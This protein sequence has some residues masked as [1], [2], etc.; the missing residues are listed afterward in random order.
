L[1]DKAQG[2][3]TGPGS[4]RFLLRAFKRILGCNTRVL[5]RMAQMDRALS[6]EYVFDKTF[7]E[8]GVR[9]VCALTHR[10]V[11]H[12][13]GM[14]GEG[15]VALYDAFLAVKDVLEDILAGGMGHLAGRRVLAFAE[16]SLEMEPLAGLASVGLAELGRRMGLAEPE[17]F[18]VTATGMRALAGPDR[19]DVLAEIR[20]AAAGLTAGPRGL[21][22]TLA[23][24]GPEAAGR[25]LAEREVADIE[26]AL[27]AIAAFASA[28]AGAR[29]NAAGALAVCI[30]PA[31]EARLEGW[32]E[33]RA[34]DPG[35]PPSMLVTFRPGGST[36]PPGRAWLGRGVPHSVCRGEFPLP[37]KAADLA[38]LGL[39]A[40][41]LLGGA[42]RLGW[43]LTPAGALRI[44]GVEPAASPGGSGLAA[45]G[46]TAAPGNADGGFAADAD[47]NP[48]DLLALA[49]QIAC[50]GVAAGPLVLL[51]EETAPESVP[52]GAVGFAH[53]ATP[54][55]SRLVPRLGA[56]LA[57]V[58]TAASHL[59][60][61]ARENRVPALF[62]VKGLVDVVPGTM[63]TVDADGG[64]VYRGVAEGLLRQ[65]ASE[66]TRAGFEP[67]YV[68]LRRLLRHIRPLSLVDPR[69]V[70][71]TPAHCRTCHDII[72]FVH[73][74]AVERLLSI[75][76]ADTSGLRA[77]RRFKGQ[78]PISLGIVDLDGGLIDPQPG[79]KTAV[80]MEQI[81]SLPLRAFLTGF[82]DPDA[83]R[84]DPANL[85]MKDIA[86]GM[87]RTS[88]LLSAAPETIGQ[89]LAMVAKEYANITLRLGYHFSVVDALVSE[90]PEHTFVY[91]RFAGGFADDSR[92]A[93]RATLIFAALVRLGFR[94]SRQGD[95]VVGKRNLMAMDEALEVLRLLGALSAFTRQLDVELTSEEEAER[96]ARI[97]FAR[98]D[99]HERARHAPAEG[100]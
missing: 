93:R 61:V 6:G 48:E 97:F 85:S 95:L 76:A 8:S 30:R 96:F 24:A 40:E 88:Q 35:L 25:I 33:T 5:E 69:D 98:F 50:G 11:Y 27:R 82:M 38:G 19:E 94:A 71:F 100:A 47:P 44:T 14:S 64:A 45:D 2:A 37:D 66:E 49:G 51:E 13:N 34:V 10:T 7:L 75:D 36:D 28:D 74:K 4:A 87:G 1:K 62:G 54:A 56:L 26:E 16:L 12:L 90:R 67:E 83:Q 60:T 39:A 17:G 63:V 3:E 59:A 29:E 91:F 72:H 77:P 15:H 99:V 84:L 57:E 68:L 42:C 22:L 41:R 58:G 80:T 9:D 31:M 65:A 20:R 73:E 18:A 92:R 52:L 86:A 32:L 21:T 46:P 78:S 43:A 81:A 53:A 89:N 55:L 23:E 79:A 70:N